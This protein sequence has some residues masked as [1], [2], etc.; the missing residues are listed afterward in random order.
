MPPL[1][2]FPNVVK[3]ALTYDNSP[4]GTP[5]VCQGNNIL[6]IQYSS[7]LSF[8][9]T[10]LV[11][12]ANGAMTWWNAHIMTFVSV[13]WRLTQVLATAVDGSGV[14]GVSTHAAYP[15]VATGSAIANNCAS[16]ISW[17]GAPS[18]R[19]GKPRTYLPGVPGTQ[20]TGGTSQLNSSFCTSLKAAAI[21]ALGDMAWTNIMSVPAVLG[22]VS[23]ISKTINPTPPHHRT[24]PLFW[25]YLSANVHSR[26]DSQR[27]RSGKER[28]YSVV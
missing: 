16:C 13:S 12:I 3:L 4:S 25:P 27:R 7:P 9:A 1:P 22:A 21:A 11:G 17:I 28:I 24:T 8:T 6:H 14:Q 20:V 23:Y 2:A 19:G 5:P 18:Y 15:G 10:E 26:V